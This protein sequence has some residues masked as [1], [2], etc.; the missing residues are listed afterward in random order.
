[1]PDGRESDKIENATEA[2]KQIEDAVGRAAQSLDTSD[3]SATEKELAKLLKKSILNSLKTN[4][5]E[6]QDKI[7]D[8]MSA[9]TPLGQIDSGKKVKI[10]P[11][12]KTTPTSPTEEPPSARATENKTEEKPPTETEKEP[13]TA[14]VETTPEGLPLSPGRA[15]EPAPRAERPLRAGAAEESPTAPAKEDEQQKSFST[16]IARDRNRQKM[17]GALSQKMEGQSGTEAKTRETDDKIKKLKKLRRTLRAI[18]M[19]ERGC[20]YCLHLT[21]VLSFF[22]WILWFFKLIL[23]SIPI[24]IISIIITAL[25]IK[26]N[27]QK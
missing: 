12:Q 13:F 4:K 21:L 10:K 16:Q 11:Q 1:M 15:D 20:G 9:P 19:S 27:L 6:S 26:K 3:K 5:T 22:A 18:S 24:L 2:E 25:K 7:P 17:G 8:I 14:P 23:I